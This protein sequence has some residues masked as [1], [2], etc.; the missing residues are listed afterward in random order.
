MARRL[1]VKL[2]NLFGGPGTGKSTTA[3]GLFHLLKLG[4]YRCELVPEYAKDLV[5][6]NRHDTLKDQLYIFAKQHRKFFI[7]KEHDLDFIVTD[8]PLLLAMIYGKENTPAFK[9]LIW[10]RHNSFDNVNIFLNR[11]KPYMKYGRLQ[12]HH[13]AV[14]LDKDIR[15]MLELN[16]PKYHEFDADETAPSN[17]ATFLESLN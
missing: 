5:W 6:E 3:A 11:V 14:K 16:T 7:L 15:E 13:E 9:S 2:I 4:G 1:E 17:I 12:E 10:E 8:S